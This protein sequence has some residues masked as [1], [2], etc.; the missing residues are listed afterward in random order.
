MTADPQPAGRDQAERV[1]G[2]AYLPGEVIGIGIEGARV[3]VSSA[4]DADVELLTVEF[5]NGTR[6][7]VDV[8]AEWI[9][10]QRQVPAD[11]MPQPGEIWEDSAGGRWFACDTD[12]M[13]ASSPLAYRMRFVSPDRHVKSASLRELLDAGSLRRVWPAKGGDLR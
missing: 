6:V 10:V 11:G 13:S 3:V 1:A 8:R 12:G 5:R 7:V 9:H 4:P 2:P